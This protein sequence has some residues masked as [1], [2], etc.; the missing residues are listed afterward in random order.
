TTIHLHPD[1]ILRLLAAK[2]Q[3]CPGETVHRPGIDKGYFLGNLLILRVGIRKFLPD[4][5][6]VISHP[7]TVGDPVAAG[8]IGKYTGSRPGREQDNHSQDP[9]ADCSFHLYGSPPAY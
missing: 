1:G 2:Y 6:I 7:K 3:L 8:E 5:H 4:L 9:S